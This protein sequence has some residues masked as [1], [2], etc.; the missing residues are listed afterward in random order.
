MFVSGDWGDEYFDL[1]F[2]LKNRIIDSLV[3]L[4]YVY[5]RCKALGDFFTIAN[6]MLFLDCVV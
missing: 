4:M 6:Y 1:I 3:L 5:V 2:L